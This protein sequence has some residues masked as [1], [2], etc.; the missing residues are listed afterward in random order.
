ML[1]GKL[2][3]DL[4]HVHNLT[5][6]M[7]LDELIAFIGAADVLVAASTGP[8]HIAAACGIQAIGLYADRRPIHPGRWAPLGPKAVAITYDK[9][10]LKGEEDAS[11]VK[12]E[13][14]RIAGLIL[15]GE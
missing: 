12:I 2:P 13:P 3:F 10:I 7:S 14:A 8:L 15:G 6:K 11:I 9:P 1:E 4:P 5:G